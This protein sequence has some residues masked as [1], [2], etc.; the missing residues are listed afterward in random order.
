MKKQ[1]NHII[2]QKIQLHIKNN[3]DLSLLL[4]DISIKGLDLSHSRISQFDRPDD[5]LTGCNLKGCVIGEEGKITNISNSILRNCNFSDAQFKGKLWMR[6]CDAR[7]V[8][9]RGADLSNAD[10]RFTDFTGANLCSV[11]I[12]IGSKEGVGAILDDQF[13][14]DLTSQW[15]I[16][17]RKRTQ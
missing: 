12:R 14:K 16:E 11:I 13:M 2:I 5:D 9:F 3:L 8:D 10:Y 1:P 7:G 17:V 4:K 15:Q 6:H